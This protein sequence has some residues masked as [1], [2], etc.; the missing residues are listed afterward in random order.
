MH[1]VVVGELPLKKGGGG[2][3]YCC[4]EEQPNINSLVFYSRYLPIHPG[5]EPVSLHYRKVR[6][7][8]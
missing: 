7:L 6:G 4:V 1:I 8:T 5:E 3:L 2:L